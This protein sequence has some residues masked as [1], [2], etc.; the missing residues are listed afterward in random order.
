MAGSRERARYFRSPLLPETELLTASYREHCFARHWHDGFVVAVIEAGAESFFYRGARH[1]AAAGSLAVIN[2][3][4]IHTGQKAA[5]EGWRYRVFYPAVSV[6]QRAASMIAGHEAPPPWLP[7]H[8]IDDPPLAAQLGRAHRLLEAGDDPL[9]AE[10]AWV[11]AASRLILCH[12]RERPVARIPAADA[13]RVAAMQGRL[14]DDLAGA[15]SLSALASGVGLSP[16]H[17]AR[18]F[19]RSVGLPPH[20]WRNQLRLNRA[21]DLLRAGRSAAEA[22]AATGFTD[23]S[24]LT[25]HFKRAFGAPPGQW[26]RGA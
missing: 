26:A 16:F 7:P 1:V 13:R 14:A 21:A 11:E 2:P 8:V 12:A 5:E 20:A 19:S 23:Q 18:L 24:H 10:T 15:V 9:A 25:R 3:G 17:A 4:E 6:L 22:A